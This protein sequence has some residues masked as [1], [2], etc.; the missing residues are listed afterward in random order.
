M[1]RIDGV[2]FPHADIKIKGNI[3]NQFSF[4]ENNYVL[5]VATSNTL[6]GTNHL[7]SL[8]YNLRVLN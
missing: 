2:F 5:R 3:N 6:H 1:A 4:D 8:D 7:Y